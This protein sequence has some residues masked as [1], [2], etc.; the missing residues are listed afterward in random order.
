MLGPN[1]PHHTLFSVLECAKETFRWIEWPLLL[2]RREVLAGGAAAAAMTFAADAVGSFACVDFRA[3]AQSLG[4]GPT[5]G[6]TGARRKR[7][8]HV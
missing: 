8:G 7:S 2:S 4:P 6:A 1:D 5:L 3:R